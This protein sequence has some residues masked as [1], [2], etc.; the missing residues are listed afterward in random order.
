MSEPAR[1]FSI[2]RHFR[3]E[4]LFQV[5]VFLVPIIVAVVLAL[6]GPWLFEQFR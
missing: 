6:V 5:L 4:G 1:K 2:N 3:R